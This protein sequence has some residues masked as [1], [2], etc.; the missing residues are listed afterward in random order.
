MNPQ[1]QG[2]VFEY[3]YLIHAAKKVVA[4]DYTLFR[5]V[6]PSWDNEPRRPGRGSTYF[7]S[8]PALYHRWLTEAC[9][10]AANDPDPEKRLVFINA[11][12]EWG[13]GAHLEPD[14]RFGYGYLQATAD[15]LRK[16]SAA[17]RET[18]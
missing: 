18:R 3:A 17:Q 14:R 2:R 5:G 13:E 16:F 15:A 8:T 6:C 11:W 7:D 1:Y 12:N 4:P 10:F 9:A